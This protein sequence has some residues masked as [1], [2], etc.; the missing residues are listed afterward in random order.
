MSSFDPVSLIETAYRL[1]GGL[2]EWK[3]E[4]LEVAYQDLDVGLGTAIWEISVGEDGRPHT[5]GIVS[6]GR[7]KEPMAELIRQT[8]AAFG[9]PDIQRHFRSDLVFGTASER[10]ADYYDDFTEDPTYQRYAHPYGVYD[11]RGILITDP[12]GTALAL[13]A[14]LGEVDST[15]VEQRERWARLGA[16]IAAGYRLQRSQLESS[17]EAEDVDAILTPT[18]ELE[19]ATSQEAKHPEMREALKRRVRS[20]DHARGELRHTEPDEA[21]ELWKGLLAG[22]YSLVDYVDSDGRRFVLARRNEPSV[23]KP[24]PLSSRERQVI[25]YAALGHSNQLIAYELGLADSTVATLLN[26]GLDKLGLESR[27]QLIQ[28]AAA[29]HSEAGVQE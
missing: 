10:M 6:K 21:V 9:D 22:R 27:F 24:R 25:H 3:E 4:I 8:T 11:F 28:L 1:D 15:S 23:D 2:G 17:P 14:V 16:H 18:G 13:G 26:R 20:I 19:A 29:L 5:G 7:A 12:S